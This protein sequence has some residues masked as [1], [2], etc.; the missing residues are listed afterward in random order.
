MKS[1]E[2]KTECSGGASVFFYG[3]CKNGFTSIAQNLNILNLYSRRQI[4]FLLGFFEKKQRKNC[5][6]HR[7]LCHNVTSFAGVVAVPN[8]RDV[9]N[10]RIKKP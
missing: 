8:I 4:M 3:L 6:L 10:R 2:K 7:I 9:M 5:S 1:E